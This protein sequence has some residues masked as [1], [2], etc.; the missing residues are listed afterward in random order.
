M[1]NVLVSMCLRFYYELQSFTLL[2]LN[3]LIFINNFDELLLV[4]QVPRKNHFLHANL[5]Q[6]L[7]IW[8]MSFILIFIIYFVNF[9]NN[10]IIMNCLV[11][12]KN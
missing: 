9:L 11:K 3:K 12:K 8:L 1:N 6:G 2:K 7:Y 5:F 4:K 10:F